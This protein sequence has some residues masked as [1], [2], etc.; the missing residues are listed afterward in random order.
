MALC[1][2]SQSCRVLKLAWLPACRMRK[3]GGKSSSS[4]KSSGCRTRL[5][6]TNKTPGSVTDLPSLTLIL[7]S[8]IPCAF[9]GGIA[10]SKT[11]ANCVR[12]T[13]CVNLNACQG[14]SESSN[15]GAVR[16]KRQGQYI[17]V[18]LSRCKPACVVRVLRGWD[19]CLFHKGE[20]R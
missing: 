13:I 1:L 14:R 3:Y 7:R 19:Y 12:A 2:R 15:V 6:A 4:N 5:S 8:V 18:P 16:R 11:K 9:Q 17:Q 10:H 20:L